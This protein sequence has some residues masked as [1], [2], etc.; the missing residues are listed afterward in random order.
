MTQEQTPATT[1]TILL[2]T[3]LVTAAAD[4][5]VATRVTLAPRL[6]AAVLALFTLLFLLRVLGQVLVVLR[7][8]AWLPPMRDE[9]WNL[10][11][12]TV[13]LP[14][15]LLVTIFMTFVIVGVSAEVAPFGA[16]RVSLGLILVALSGIYAAV[17]AL[18]YVVR[19]VRRPG[20]RWFGGAI[21]IVFHLVL[22]SFLFTWGRFHAQR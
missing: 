5:F 9:N 21:P 17:M 10:V 13:L 7:Q 2:A 6:T 22:A 16:R 3:L 1:R 14:A 11:P 18:R 4:G 8:P 15:Q 12:Y 20:Q 19:M